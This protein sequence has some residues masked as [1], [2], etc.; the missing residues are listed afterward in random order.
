MKYAGTIV[1]I[2]R[3]GTV[4]SSCSPKGTPQK[5]KLREITTNYHEKL[6]ITFIF[7]FTDVLNQLYYKL[8]HLTNKLINI[9]ENL[10]TYCSFKCFLQIYIFIIPYSQ[11]L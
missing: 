11:N 6:I 10:K 8:F 4:K 5:S 2:L 9:L 7:T 3:K 1:P